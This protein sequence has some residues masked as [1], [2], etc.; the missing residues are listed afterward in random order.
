MRFVF[1]SARTGLTDL[2]WFQGEVLKQTVS[3]HKLIKL[4]RSARSPREP[5]R[6]T[7]DAQGL[8]RP[9]GWVASGRI[10]SRILQKSAGQA[11]SGPAFPNIIYF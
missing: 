10:G 3:Q 5:V 2:G 9:A 11:G 7:V 4:R 1:E 8:G 6:Q